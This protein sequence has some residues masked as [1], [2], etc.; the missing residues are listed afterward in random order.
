MQNGEP[1]I[2]VKNLTRIF[3]N[4]VALKNIDLTIFNGELLGFV[5]P[6]GSGKTTLL[7]SICAILDPTEGS[8][9]VNGFDSVKQSSQITSRIGYMSQAYSLYGEL[10]VEE[11]LEFFARIRNIPEEVF[12]ERKNKLLEFSGLSPFLKRKTKFLSGGM[13]K[14][15]ALCCNMIHEPEILVLDEPTLGVDPLSRR[16]LWNIIY[17]YNAT[18]KTVILATS[19]MDEAERCTRFAFLFDGSLIICKNPDSISGSLE[20]LFISYIPKKQGRQQKPPFLKKQTEAIQVEVDNLVK[21]FGEFKALDNITF[22]VKSGEIFGFVGPNGS[23]KTTTIKVLCGIIPP[24]EG[25]VQVAGINVGV[26]PQLVK[27]KIG[28]MSQKFSLYTDLT[29]NENIQFFGRIY[30]VEWDDLLDRKEWVLEMSGLEDKGD[31]LVD[32]LSGAFKQ[33]L[34]LGCS[35]LHSPDIL[36]LDEPT[37]GVDPVSRRAFWDIIKTLAEMG[38]TVFVT[39]HYLNEIEKCNRVAFLHKGALLNIDDPYH[40]KTE[41]QIDDMEEIF[42]RLVKKANESSVSSH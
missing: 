24:S 9:T 28:Y 21:N 15:L 42:V 6:D 26:N 17:E 5:G 27:Q 4:I 1:I 10:T 34:A 33:R 35:L 11:N 39:T 2:E 13:Q 30:E 37:S 19:Y 32:E 40:L 12:I 7:Q 20:D 8:I 38:T 23:G 18:G 3:K 31:I 41:Y 14:K 25:K 22:D 16:H 29:V 36:F